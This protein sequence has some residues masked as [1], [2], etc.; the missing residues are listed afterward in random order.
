MVK[1]EYISPD[2]RALEKK[3]IESLAL[4]AKGLFRKLPTEEELIFYLN[5]SRA[6]ARAV[7]SRLREMMGVGNHEEGKS[8]AP[9]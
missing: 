5:I 3:E 7:L 1:I 8:Q 2:Q 9:E 6:K 4:R